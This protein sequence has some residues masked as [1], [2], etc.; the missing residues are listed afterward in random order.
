MHHWISKCFL[1][2]AAV[3]LIATSCSRPPPLV[4]VDNEKK[5]AASVSAA[6]KQKIYIAT[7]RHASGAEGVFYSGERGSEIGLASVVVSIPPGHEAGGLER[8]RSLP[9]D[10][11]KHFAI[12]EPTVYS[13]PNAFV[14]AL[15]SSLLSLPTSDRNILFFVH[16][17]N[18]TISDAILRLAQ[19]VE[20]TQYDGIPVLVSWA[21]AAKPLQNVYG[22]NSALA[23]RSDFLEASKI[24]TRSKANQVDL[25]AHSMG[26]F[27]TMEAISQAELKGEFNR[28]RRLRNVILAA[29]DIDIEVF[30][31][32]LELISHNNQEFFVLISADD[33]AL[34]FS[35]AISGGVDRV[36]AA[37]AAALSKLGV[38]VIDLSKVADSK[39]GS[40]SKFVG[41]PEIVQLIGDGIRT[42]SR[43]GKRTHSELVEFVAGA[44][45]LIISE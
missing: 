35:K 29:P 5:P 44:P 31:K 12:I 43:F 8:P 42:S 2:L 36:G 45:I 6:T 30:K 22:L 32:Q 26:A 7:T 18:T 15:D 23:A 40:H 39:S 4:G 1:P 41:S 13:S 9:P 14:R 10:P 27:L 28:S 17:Y 33:G 16:G 38:T 24:V 20:D 21:P 34:N 3:L 19:F 11:E 25:L 37:D